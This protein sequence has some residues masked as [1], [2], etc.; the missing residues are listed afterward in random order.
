MKSA[1]VLM[2]IFMVNFITLG[3]YPNVISLLVFWPGTVI[4]LGLWMIYTSY[5]RPARQGTNSQNNE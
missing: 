3:L 1:I 4:I 2:T 5:G